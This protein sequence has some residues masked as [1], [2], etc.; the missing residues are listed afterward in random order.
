MPGKGEAV[1]FPR[2]CCSG[3]LRRRRVSF[4]GLFFFFFGQA[5]YF[6]SVSM[7]SENTFLFLVKNS[8][9]IYIFIY[10]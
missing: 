5:D 4:T 6:S 2:S 9:Y 1:G 10:H 7:T 8:K 3:W